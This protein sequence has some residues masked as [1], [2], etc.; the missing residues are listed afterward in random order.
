MPQAI[1]IVSIMPFK[2]KSLPFLKLF[3]AFIV[4]TIFSFSVVSVYQLNAYTAET[5]AG[6]GYEN[7]IEELGQENK[8]LEINLAKA[9]S[10]WNIENYAQGFGKH[11]LG[12][13]A[14]IIWSVGE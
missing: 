6:Y 14:H 1:S 5:Y 10:L 12:E 9:N 11:G 13:I 3:W 7:K 8:I 4:L 2:P